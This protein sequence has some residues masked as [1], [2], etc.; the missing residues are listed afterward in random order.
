MEQQSGQKVLIID[1]EAVIRM[2]I[3]AHLEDAGYRVIEAQDGRTGIELFRSERP[4]LILVDLR[5]PKMDGLE[6]LAAVTEESSETPVIVVSGT[7][8][9][10]DV[11]EALHL[12]AWDFLLK[13]ILDMSV[14]L[15][16]VRKSLERSQLIK[17]NRL[18]QK[19]LETEVLNRTRDLK[20]AN[21]E[22]KREV[23]VRKK[24]EQALT[25]L[26]TRLRKAMESSKELESQLRQAQ[27]MEAIGTLSGG[28]AHD[29]NNILGAIIGYTEIAAIY[30]K[31]NRK[32]TE[33]LAKVLKASER[34]R[35]LVN[36]ILSFSR[37]T[38]DERKPI[39][40]GLIIKESLKLLRASLPTTIEIRHRIDVT[41]CVMKADPTQIHQVLMNLCTNAHH[42]MRG[43]GG[44]LEVALTA[45]QLDE[46]HVARFPELMP[47]GYIQL[48]VSDTGSGM[49]KK[50]LERIFDPYF[51][52]KEKSEGTGLGLSVVHGI[53]KSH[54]G[55][56]QVHS[57]P[58]SGTRFDILFPRIDI[59][60]KQDEKIRET[61][62][63]GSERILFVDDE[64]TLTEIGKHMLEHLG[65][66]VVAMT[67]PDEAIQLFAT[68]PADFDLI[69]TDMTMPNITG[70]RLTK[71]I[72]RIRSDIPVI[73]CTGFNREMNQ[74]KSREAA[75]SA[76][77]MK[78]LV[79]SK[80]AKTV[81]DVLDKGEK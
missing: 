48:T 23:A 77:L 64:E 13:P 81:R 5:M 50:T 67:R 39:E 75:I 1:D 28:I 15:H 20:I 40:I 59:A 31:D 14:L 71:E 76:F 35:D 8:I 7:G 72:K 26:N 54:E 56:I 73:L 34:A 9:I 4:Q 19:H 27:K 24:A 12:G 43:K 41:D 80:I 57:V 42:A 66:E 2:T 16:A 30:A 69:I 10:S 51:T 79:M 17:E 36:Q 11:V 6:V 29:F 68:R 60:R 32:V 58:D 52:T 37:Q 78:P 46:E 53:V 33:S 62:K 74:K 44:V 21:E 49:D 47:G 18:H 70:E 63:K 22:L 38:K 65:Y 3:M 61:L 25:L 45:V 55:E